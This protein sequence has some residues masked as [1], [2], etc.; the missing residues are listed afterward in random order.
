MNCTWCAISMVV[1]IFCKWPKS[2]LAV[3]IFK[4]SSTMRSDHHLQKVRASLR[5]ICQRLVAELGF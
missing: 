3:L 5:Q 2:L 1:N 4:L